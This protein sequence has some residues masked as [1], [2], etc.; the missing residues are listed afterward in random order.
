[1]R[2]F[3]V[4]I[5]ALVL[6]L[7]TVALTATVVA[8]VVKARSE[9]G[10]EAS[11][12]LR[13]AAGMA[14]EALRFRGNQLTN[15][16]EVLTADFGF[17]EAVASAD[18]PTLMSAMVNHQAR[19]GADALI[20]LDPSGRPIASTLPTLTSGAESD[21]HDLIGSDVDAQMLRL[22]RLIDGKPYQLVVAPVL[23]PDPI[24]WTV[25]GFALDDKV[26]SQMSA[27]LGVQ[28]SFVSGDESGPVFVASSMPAALRSGL[29]GVAR[30]EAATPFSVRVGEDEF[31]TW[32]DP[33]RSGNGS[34]T[35]VLQRSV[36]GTLR[37]YE[38]LRGSILAIGL[39]ILALASVLAALLARSA[40]RPVDEL[41]RAA[42]RLEA[43]DYETEVPTNATT[44][45]SRLA[46]AFNAMRNAVGER[47]RTIRHQASHDDLTGLPTRA[48]IT[49]VLDGVLVAARRTG[50]P[51]SVCLIEVQHLEN[52]VG[53][54][55]H[56]AADRVLC[57][58]AR[59]LGVDSED[60][61]RVARIGTDQFLSILEGVDARHAPLHAE[62]IGE[63]LR[64]A[65]DYRAV[66]LQ[67][68]TRIGIGAFPDDGGR[69]EELL[70]CADLALVRAR[71][72]GVTVGTFVRGDDEL[73]RHRLAVL[74]DLRRAIAADE[75]ELHYQPKVSLPS[76]APVGC[77]ALVRW[78]HPQKGFI[79]PGDFIPHAERTGLIRLVTAWVLG[80][81]LRQVRAWEAAGL[82]LDVSVNV[83]PADL[84]DPGFA[85]TL[86]VMLAE[87][88]ADASRVVLE[89]TESAAMKDL[90]KTLRVMEQ[91]RVLGIRFS[92][93][94]FGTGYSSLAHLKRLPV[95]EIK[96]DRSFVQELETRRADDVIVRSTINLGHA[97]K[98]KVVAEG[99]EVPYSWELLNQLGCD[100]VQ[101]YFV[102]RPMP[103]EEFTAWASARLAP[104]AP[105]GRARRAAD[106]RM[107][108][109]AI[110]VCPVDDDG[111]VEIGSRSA[112]GAAR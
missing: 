62:S 102:A 67:L 14:R 88:G 38:Q 32:S 19:I 59:R 41:I 23:A 49:E 39:A 82:N 24:A 13:A 11:L 7:V 1:M 61:S 65:F 53:S 60:R 99:V 30:R 27:L 44:E 95:D 68:E 8:V 101:G 79:P 84:G 54:F 89:V 80:A 25:V 105:T 31:L 55:G 20:V 66:S 112:N 108:A 87:T 2:S 107:V 90:P 37:P 36:T 42:E 92:I 104:I 76:G 15:A 100:L 22:Y 56:A 58:I 46:R 16:A 18:A 28:V 51:V 109:C 40:T 35:L 52:I 94:D 98:L 85:D 86:A 110:D 12:Q 43:G 72:S 6:G 74:G 57:E 50:R 21:L 70:Q 93:D 83:S 73:H 111:P 78:R 45:L 29:G 91:L 4:R 81:A 75:L 3:R 9:V 69:A 63:R 17:K 71:E 103:A 26:A 77:E 64:E 10:R 5:L 96:I 34:L 106:S 33:I 97:L 47:E 48:R